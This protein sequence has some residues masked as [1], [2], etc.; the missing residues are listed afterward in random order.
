[1]VGLKLKNFL[2]CNFLYNPVIGAAVIFAFLVYSG[3]LQPPAKDKFKC[4]LPPTEISCISGTVCSNAVKRTSSPFYFA[5][6]LPEYAECQNGAASTCAGKVKIILPAAFVESY[7]PGKLYSSVKGENHLICEA[8]AKLELK[9]AFAK[10]GS[11]FFV[12]NAKQLDWGMDFLSEVRKFRA[13][14]RM[15]FRRMLYTWGDAGGLLL[16]LISGIKEYADSELCTG[17]KNAGLSHILALSGMHLSLFSGM[18]LFAG[19]N[20][21]GSRFA[22]FLQ[23][24]AVCIF[25]WFAGTS[26]SLFR[27]LLCSF[28]VIFTKTSGL[29]SINSL[30][31]L[32]LV[33]LIHALIFP[34]H[35]S[36]PAFML[37]YGALAGIL[38]FGKI[39]FRIFVNII[40][41]AVSEPLG[42]SAGAQLIASPVTACV[43][44]SFAPIG[45][46]SSVIVS[47]ITSIFIYSGLFCIAVCLFCPA[48][49]PCSSLFMKIQ[50]NIIKRLV[51]IFAGFPCVNV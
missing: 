6:F 49:V 46:V 26:P 9:G 28:I 34:L 36:E 48:L 4:L 35:V 5:Q 7:F 17:F 38:I 44:K 20:F 19:K 42:T 24:F 11:A 8:G 12:K 21:F 39:F 18:A 31:N 47:P 30:K 51:L 16:A 29:A 43:F 2:K 27:A 1:M 25:T 3:I 33:F 37:S 13:S 22:I 14:C 10:D 23:L 45:I 32:S 50:Y 40:P 41:P 15:Q